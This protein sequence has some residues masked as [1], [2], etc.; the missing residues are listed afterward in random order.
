MIYM[1]AAKGR[2]P[3][4]MPIVIEIQMLVSPR[5]RKLEEKYGF[6][7][8]C[9]NPELSAQCTVMP[10]EDFGFDAAVHMS[11]LSILL[12]A[13]GADI[14]FG[15]KDPGRVVSNPIRTESD[16]EKF[17]IPDPE[18]T[19]GIWFEGMRLG[20]KE[21]EIDVVGFDW[22]IRMEDAVKRL[23]EKQ[24]VQGNLEPHCLFAPDDV[25][26]KRVKD[27]VKQGETAPAHIFS[28]GGW[29]VRGTPPEKVKFLVDLVHSL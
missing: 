24:V 25:I 16:I 2:R 29:I 18:E 23:G 28:L 14:K 20:K 7:G 4:K 19:M 8:I 13:F 12:E 10:I 27:I 6:E 26:E 5:F 22:T 15:L 17:S 11:D 1:E 21:I 3:S 9:K